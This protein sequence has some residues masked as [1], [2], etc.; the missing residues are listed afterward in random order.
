MA[1][2][3]NENSR[4][5]GPALFSYG[6]RPFFLGAALFAGVAVPA[7]ILMLAGLLGQEGLSASRDW[8]VHEML[9]GFLPAVIT[10]FL[11]TAVPNWTDRPP[12]RGHELILLFGLWLAGR[13]VIAVPWFT[14][15]LSALVDGAFLVALAGLLWR[16][17]ARGKS[18]GHAP[19]GLLISLYAGANILFHLLASRDATTDLP[20][21]MALALVMMLLT[22]VGGRVTPNF[23]REFLAGA[24]KTERPALFSR[25]DGVAIALVGIAAVAWIVEPQALVTGWLLMAAGFVNLGR[26]SRWYGWLTW[27]EPLV[28]SLHLGYG[29]LAMALLFIAGATLGIGLL[30]E[31]AVHALTTGAVGVMTLAVMTRASLGHTG[32]PRHAGPAT[33][34][35]YMLVMLGALLR[36][37]GPAIELPA[38]LMLAVAAGCWSGAYLL[39]A[40]VYGPFLVRP[41]LDE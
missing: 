5:L 37:F 31:D 6:F 8:H 26:L 24:R 40:V 21:R 4:Y 28:L 15:L 3:T 10:G 2:R 35:M 29:W 39:F 34:C 36:T 30:K 14:P 38:T 20:E 19:M 32:R 18:W 1:D 16:E 7:W 33:I 41:S 27:R 25:F 11:L 13:L 17:I 22:F 12:I 23:T 9:F